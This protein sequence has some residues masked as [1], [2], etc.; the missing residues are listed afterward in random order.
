MKATKPSEMKVFIGFTRN[1]SQNK[2]ADKVIF[3]EKVK[4]ANHLLKQLGFPWF[5]FFL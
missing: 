2:Y 5:N 4:I 1:P 3:K